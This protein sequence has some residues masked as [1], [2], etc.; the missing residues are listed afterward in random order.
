[1]RVNSTLAC[2]ILIAFVLMSAYALYGCSQPIA[3]DVPQI[4]FDVPITDKGAQEIG[5]VH[6]GSEIDERY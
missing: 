3:N 2:V 4:A 1:M 6:E 5:V